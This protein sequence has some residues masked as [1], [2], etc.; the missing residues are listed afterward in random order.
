[1][2]DKVV[3]P[4]PNLVT[5]PEPLMTPEKL[6]ASFRLK[7]NVALLVTS[8]VMLPMLLP[9]PICNVPAEMVVPPE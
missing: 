7:A 6:T 3:V 8:P 2:P 5:A 1:M 9:A 4:V